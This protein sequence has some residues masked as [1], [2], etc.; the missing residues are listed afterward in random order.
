MLR[1]ILLL[2]GV[3]SSLLYLALNIVVPMY[4]EG[5]SV[6]TQTVSEL[7]AIGAP[8]RS[9]WVAWCTV[10][11]LLVAAFGWGVWQSAA[12]NRNLRIVGAL[13]VFDGLFGIFWPP[14]QLR[15]HE[16]ATTDILHIAFGVVTV[17]LMMLMIG[18]GAA[19]LGKRFRT[20]SIVSLVF[21]FVFGV[22]TG[23]ESPNIAKNLPTPM[24]GVWERINIGVFMLWMV[25][26]AVV[27]LRY[28]NRTST[29]K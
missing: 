4:F 15:G 27:L 14:M 13:L 16:M 10:Y 3:L 5:Y 19:A 20:Y 2:C 18:F 29:G 25:V 22:L 11:T 24:I 23:L 6:K 9:M 12:G 21:F 28:S 8:T 26:F 1:K 7:S 17:V